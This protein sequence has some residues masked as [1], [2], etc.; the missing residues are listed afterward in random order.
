MA[1]TFDCFDASLN[2]QLVD[3]DAEKSLS[4]KH[5][6][7]LRSSLRRSVKTGNISIKAG[8]ASPKTFYSARDNPYSTRPGTCQTGKKIGLNKLMGDTLS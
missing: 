3:A 6:I 1:G 5:D 8:H 7:Q 2:A 4:A